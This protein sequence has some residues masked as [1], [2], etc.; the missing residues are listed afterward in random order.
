MFALLGTL[1]NIP[2]DVAPVSDIKMVA[3]SYALQ[4]Q[5][6]VIESCQRRRVCGEYSQNTESCLRMLN[7]EYKRHCSLS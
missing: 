3:N 4:K 1:H 2:R 7:W 5:R 6:V